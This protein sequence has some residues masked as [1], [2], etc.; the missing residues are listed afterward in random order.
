MI[1]PIARYFRNGVGVVITI[2]LMVFMYSHWSVFSVTQNISSTHLILIGIGVIFTWI[3]NSIQILLLFRAQKI[4]IGFIENLIVQTMTILCNYLPMRIGT[5]L[6]FRYFKTVHGLEYSRFGG[7][8]AA[9]ALILLI[10]SIFITVV[11]MLIGQFIDKYY[12]FVI[13]ISTLI[14]LLL[15][16]Y[17]RYNVSFTIGNKVIRQLL[18]AFYSALQS[19]RN[20]PSLSFA[21]F[22]LV[23]IQISLLACRL[24]FCFVAMGV[25]ISL[26]SLFV[27]APAG[28]VLSFV[29]ISPGNFGVREW[30]MGV[31]TAAT[32]YNFELAIFAG[33]ID[34]LVLT[35]LTFI[36]GSMSYGYVW[37][38]TGVIRD[39]H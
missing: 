11:A 35:V 2:W 12:Q 13:I 21:L 8:M 10:A 32:G 30:V 5:I 25:D 17:Y 34:R 36:F 6:R 19:I 7:I 31:V 16:T 3:I 4:Q 28:I 29:T 27:V 18:C 24:Y 9:R 33:M 14:V 1:S 26:S 22:L 39:T 38:K 23:L 20:S 15:V 37:R